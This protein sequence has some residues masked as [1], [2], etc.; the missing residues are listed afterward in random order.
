MTQF[1]NVLFDNDIAE[2]IDKILTYEQPSEL[3]LKNFYG[4]EGE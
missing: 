1:T 3:T 4:V 2:Q